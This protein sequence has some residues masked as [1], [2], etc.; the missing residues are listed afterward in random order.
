MDQW[1]KEIRPWS[2]K[3][4]DRDRNV[5]L[6]I[7]GIPAHAWN[8][9]FFSQISKLWGFFV[10]VDDATMEKLSMDV[11]RIMIRTSCQQVI[12]EFID[13]KVNDDFYHLRVLEDSYGPMC[14]IIPQTIGK[15]GNINGSDVSD[16]DDDEEEEEERWP[17]MVE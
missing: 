6:R 17:E 10:N 5:W 15:E 1:F 7:H 12:D 9:L 3:E 4:I 14:I 11:A 2:P 13:V 16:E 8:D